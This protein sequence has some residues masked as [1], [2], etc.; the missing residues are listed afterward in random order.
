MNRWES[1][2]L[3]VCLCERV[4]V[5]HVCAQRKLAFVQHLSWSFNDVLRTCV[6]CFKLSKKLFESVDATTIIDFI[7]EINFYHLVQF[8]ILLSMHDVRGVK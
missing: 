8:N 5:V 3:L 1:V 7:K 6:S 4:D 2:K